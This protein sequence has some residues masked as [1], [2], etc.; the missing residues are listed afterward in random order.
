ML[1]LESLRHFLPETFLLCG[2]FFILLLDLFQP[3]KKFLGLLSILILLLTL[4]LCKTPAQTLPL[5]FDFFRLDLTTHFFRMIIIPMVILSLLVSL[6]YRGLP[7]NSAG[8]YYALF[9]LMTF[10][11][12]IMAASTNLLMLFISIEFVSILSYL[13]TGLL[14]KD[15]RSK[16]AAIKYLLFG[17]ICSAMM[18]Y[19]MSLLY[20]MTGSIQFEALRT[21][22]MASGPFHTLSLIALFF[23]LVGLGF[24]ITM[25][26]FHLW[27]ADV[28]EAAPTP[29]SGFLTVAPKAVGFA[30]LIRALFL[31]FRPLVAEWQTLIIAFSILTMTLGNFTAIA[32]SN[33][34]RLLA[35]SSIAQAG[36]ILVGLAVFQPLGTAS[37]FLYLVVYALTNL[38][39]FAVVS[40]VFNETESDDLLAY[41]GL[42]KRSPFLA[43]C[44]TF[45]LLSLA[46]IPPLAGFI[47]KFFIF[48]SAIQQGFITLAVIAALNSAVAAFYYFKV[49]RAMY[50]V[51]PLEDTSFDPA[52]YV[53]AAIGLTFLAVLLLGLF[54]HSLLQMTFAF[55]AGV[56]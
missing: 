2:A 41:S 1:A 27:A 40:A 44:L 16:E 51:P 43:A 38:G 22:T 31:I 29:V 8:E 48:S 14:K 4:L 13:M 49:V 25:A 50:L 30:I 28:Y 10:A 56:S 23:F 33:I 24:K 54:P 12:I 39:A 52:L 15:P 5:F 47:G 7:Q 18:L 55:L 34:K 21:A 17:S 19:G 9:L 32:Q 36:Y 20:G 46:G 26:P 42:A 35:F 53:K 6:D 11:L 3:E 37:V 45:F